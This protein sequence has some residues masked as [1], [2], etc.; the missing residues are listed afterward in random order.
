MV[1][2]IPDGC[3]C[4]PS[5]RLVRHEYTNEKTQIQKPEQGLVVLT[6][7]PSTEETEKDGLL[8]IRGQP[9]LHS[10]SQASPTCAVKP[11]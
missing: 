10:A 1:A 5:L 6:L 2:E 4:G 11:C 9:G 8:R 3:W 7:I